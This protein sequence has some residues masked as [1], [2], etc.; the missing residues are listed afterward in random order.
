MVA[1]EELEDAGGA[2][3]DERTLA[4]R[5]AVRD[6]SGRPCADCAHE[7]CGHEVVLAVLLG[8][9]SAPRCA[10][11]L[12]ART[13]EDAGELCARVLAWLR[14]RDCYRSAWELASAREGAADALRPPCLF[15]SGAEAHAPARV[16]APVRETEARLLPSDEF[17]DAGDM[18]CGELVLEL[19]QRLQPLAAGSVLRVTATDTAAP[20]DLPAWC[21]LTGQRLLSARPPLYWIEKRPRGEPR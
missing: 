17:F 8:F 5:A 21:G 15:P 18:A 13:G 12:A 19:R 20:V 3:M 10:P 9:Q 14:A 11:C 6:L 16:R 7:L 4:L 1:P 2:P